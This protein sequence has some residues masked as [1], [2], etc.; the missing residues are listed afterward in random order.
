MRREARHF[1]SLVG[2][3][4][5]KE[6]HGKGEGH[7]GVS[8]PLC[9]PLPVLPWL[10]R[11]RAPQ[12]EMTARCCASPSAS[13]PPLRRRPWLH[14]SSGIGVGTN[15]PRQAGRRAEVCCARG[16][17]IKRGTQRGV[18]LLSVFSFRRVSFARANEMRHYLPA[19]VQSKRNGAFSLC[20]RKRNAASG[21]CVFCPFRRGKISAFV[22]AAAPW[23]W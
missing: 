23:A 11:H 4:V 1:F 12:A 9:N 10:S 19:F 17:I 6:K 15:L 2:K 16:E 18:P 13:L 20:T 21:S 22:L 7:K 14:R 5:A 3:E 8:L